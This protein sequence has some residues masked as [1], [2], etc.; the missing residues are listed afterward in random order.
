MREAPTFLP[1]DEQRT[2]VVARGSSD[3]IVTS[4]PRRAPRSTPRPAAAAQPATPRPAVAPAPAAAP[5]MAP[6]AGPFVPLPGGGA[7][8]DPLRVPMPAELAAPVYGWLR[9]LALQADLPGA[10]RLLRDAVADLTG[11]LSVVVVYAG[12]D[13]PM[14][15]GGDDELPADPQPVQL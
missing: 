10:D 14:T 4:A 15:L 8:F 13:G 5:M 11:S 1:V 12:P 3:S 7:S 6:A 2:R 9:R